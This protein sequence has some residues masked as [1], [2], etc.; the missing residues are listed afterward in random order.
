[1]MNKI[2][3]IENLELNCKEA[4]FSYIPS[5]KKYQEVWI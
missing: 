4:N 1:M 5:H 3:H 2:S